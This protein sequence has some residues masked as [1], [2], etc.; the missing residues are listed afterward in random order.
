[1]ARPLPTFESSQMDARGTPLSAMPRP[2]AAT[3]W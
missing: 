1:M 3:F 2:T